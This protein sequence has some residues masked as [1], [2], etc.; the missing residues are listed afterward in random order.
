MT[1]SL[2]VHWSLLLA[3]GN[4]GNTHAFRQFLISNSLLPRFR[5]LLCNQFGAQADAKDVVLEVFL[6]IHLK[7][8]TRDSKRPVSPWISAIARNKLTDAM[9]RRGRRVEAPVGYGTESL[10]GEDD[11]DPAMDTSLEVFLP[12]LASP[13]RDIVDLVS[14]EGASLRDAAQQLGISEEAVRVACYRALKVLADFHQ[15]GSI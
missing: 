3:H 1:Q 9:R 12:Q 6:A 7:R 4:A 2:E 15:Q 11:F 14:L 13:Q 8:G 10:P 5:E